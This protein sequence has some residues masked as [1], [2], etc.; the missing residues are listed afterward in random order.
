MRDV[1]FLVA[2]PGVQTIAEQGLPRYESSLWY[3]MLAPA[4]APQAVI[5]RAHAE[6]VKIVTSPEILIGLVA[7][8]LVSP[9]NPAHSSFP[10][11]TV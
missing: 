7:L 10:E 8:D 2:A 4:A 11:R 6:T 1:L 9:A 3:A 5:K